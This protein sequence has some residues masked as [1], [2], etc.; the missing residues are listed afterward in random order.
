MPRSPFDPLLAFQR[1]RYA[2]VLALCRAHLAGVDDVALRA[3]EAEI[4]RQAMI[5]LVASESQPNLSVMA[6]SAHPGYTQTVEGPIGDRW[7]PAGEAVDE[8]EQVAAARAKAL[9]EFPAGNLQP[10]NATQ[11]N[12]A[13]YLSA[14]ER[15]DT[16]LAGAFTSGAHLSHGA[17]SSLAGKLYKIEHYRVPSF[18]GSLMLEHLEE[19]I[20]QT[21]PRLI[22]A[23]GSAYPREIPYADIAALAKANDAL[24]L[25]DISHT[26]GFVAAGIHNPVNAAD[27]CTFST[28]KTLCGPR[29]GVILCRADFQDRINEAVFPMVQG[30]LFPNMIAAKA[31]CLA[32][33]STREFKKLQATIVENARA[34]AG[35]FAEEKIP[36][37]TG[38][39]DSHLLVI[40][41]DPHR[42]ARADVG[43]LERLGILSNANYTHGDIPREK[44]MTGI[45]LGTTWITQL[46]FRP[47]HM[48]TLGGVI[49]EALRDSGGQEHDLRRRLERLLEDVLGGC[50]AASGR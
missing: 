7:Y 47:G 15:D 17:K 18:D 19:R 1:R 27:F 10:H 2:P 23:G 22:I 24:L 41:M 25:A 49:V 32:N 9:F 26:A 48:G 31:V 36:M 35:V 12:Q 6:A 38:G 28:H 42:D 34:M 3:I 20:K 50:G 13:V 4:E 37:F 11:A 39:T 40:R 44:R 21:R 46:G 45:R 33:A 5:N 30:A 43:R 29:A 8:L 14:V 16:I